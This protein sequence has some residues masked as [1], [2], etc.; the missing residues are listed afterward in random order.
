M[1]SIVINPLIQDVI[2][3]EIN[4]ATMKKISSQ[5]FFSHSFLENK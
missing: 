3:H 4:W 1:K 2:T 5:S